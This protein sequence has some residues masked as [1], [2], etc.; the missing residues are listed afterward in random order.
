MQLGATDS[1]TRLWLDR[2]RVFKPMQSKVGS[3]GVA[4]AAV[5]ALPDTGPMTLAPP[6][7][8]IASP[9]GVHSVPFHPPLRLV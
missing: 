2:S 9:E 1:G 4:A 3:R 8:P 5:L 7:A 6:S